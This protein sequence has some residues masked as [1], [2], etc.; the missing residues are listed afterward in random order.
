M[1]GRFADERDIELAHGKQMGAQDVA[2]F[3]RQ[4]MATVAA[5]LRQETLAYGFMRDDGGLVGA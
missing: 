5:Q 1:L 3:G 4:K 2:L